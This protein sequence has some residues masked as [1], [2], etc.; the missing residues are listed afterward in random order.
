MKQ[1]HK[2][3]SNKKT[4]K[5]EEAKLRRLINNACAKKSRDKERQ[6]LEELDVE[7]HKVMEEYEK[8]KIRR[9]EIKL[10][11][12]KQREAAANINNKQ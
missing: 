4:S 11:V 12:Q 6:T 1:P 5:K 2:N 10:I 8:L 7:L 9:D 3:S